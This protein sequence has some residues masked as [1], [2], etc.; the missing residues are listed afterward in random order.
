MLIGFGQKAKSSV[1]PLLN[2]ITRI[3][4]ATG[5]ISETKSS[6]VVIV[7]HGK[8]VDPPRYV[9]QAAPQGGLMS[10]R[11][12][13]VGKSQGR[14]VIGRIGVFALLRKQAHFQLV[15]HYDTAGRSTKG[16]H[17]K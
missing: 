15:T 12:D 6:I 7:E 3:I 17:R 13:E 9:R 8:P 5:V 4:M 16:G 2:W 1:D 14:S 10:R 11:V